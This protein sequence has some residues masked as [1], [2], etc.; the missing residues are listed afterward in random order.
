MS[1]H[2]ERIKIGEIY[3]EMISIDSHI[4]KSGRF[5]NGYQQ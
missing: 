4:T 2:F 3:L 1:N 5:K